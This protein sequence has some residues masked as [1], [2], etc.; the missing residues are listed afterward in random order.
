MHAYIIIIMTTPITEE[1]V[2]VGLVSSQYYAPAS[3]ENGAMMTTMIQQQLQQQQLLR[4]QSRQRLGLLVV[5]ILYTFLYIGAFF[6]WGQMQLLLE[7]NGAFHSKCDN[8]NTATATTATT[9]TNTNTVCTAQTD[10]LIRV[11]LIAQTTQIAAPLLGLV[12][13]R[14]GAATAYYV[15]TCGIWTG[16]ALLLVAVTK[17]TP[18]D[19]SSTSS[20]SSATAAAWRDWLLYVAFAVLALGVWMGGVLTVQVGLYFCH[21]RTRH[22]VISALNALFDA[23]AV[24]YLGLWQLH[25][26]A[27]RGV[28]SVSVT[29]GCYFGLAVALFGTGLYFWT[30]AVPAAAADDDAAEPDNEFI[31]EPSDSLS[32]GSAPDV[33]LTESSKEKTDVASVACHGQQQDRVHES[34]SSV[35]I[36]KSATTNG[37][38][39]S[40][41]ILVADRSHGAQ[42]TSGPALCLAVF[43][44]V[45]GTSNQW[46][47]ATT[48][49]FLA[50]LGDD[51][52]GNK[53]LTIFTLL[54]PASLLAL[55]LVDLVIHR[56][57]FHWAFQGVNACALAFALVRLCSDNL[58]VQI[59]GFLFFSV[60][61]CFLFSVSFSYIPT[62]LS[63]NLIGLASGILFAIT[64]ITAFFNIP[65]AK[66]TVENAGGDFFVP[67]LLYTLLILPCLACAFGIGRSIERESKSRAARVQ[68]IVVIGRAAAGG[69]TAPPQQ[70]VLI[71]AKPA[72]S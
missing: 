11:Q 58:N 28:M 34:D 30:V 68:R 51:E 59:A 32:N 23:G 48:R 69:G 54:M 43:F 33:S 7:E 25:R 12:A 22:R 39:S 27:P 46:T 29:L 65:L 50:S 38:A 21:P 52:L 6:G 24:T 13:D 3:A 62:L 40:S 20:S 60:F 55:P 63:G 44:G 66:W 2:A 4:R 35:T 1:V 36:E 47:L 42:L 5:S 53:Y 19:D 31:K 71:V 9:T 18:H 17:S 56:C 57:G 45:H 37:V 16:L 10:A 26:T 61:R 70:R 41:Y 72:A 14:C 15:M 49:D 67:N 64:G 8:D